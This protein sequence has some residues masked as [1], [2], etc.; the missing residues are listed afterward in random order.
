VI[1]TPHLVFVH[2]PRTGGTFVRGVLKDHLP[3]IQRLRGYMP[4]APYRVLDPSLRD[5]PGFHVIRNPWD[6]Y[7][8]WYHHMEARGPVLAATPPP[9]SPKKGRPSKKLLEK[10]ARLR[11]KQAAW[12]DAFRSGQASFREVVVGACDGRIALGGAAERRE[13]GLG[14]YSHIVWEIAERGVGPGALEALRYKSLRP[15]LERF[16][17]RHGLL[18]DRLRDAIAQD[19]PVDTSAHRP[20]R[21][22]YD[23]QL[24]DLVGLHAQSLIERYGYVF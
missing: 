18:G 17:D 5:R 20:Y 3:P 4:T 21:S 13:S 22:Y 10:Q 19:P 23:N 1:V 8:S 7:V 16:L 11:G 15:D 2:V 12:T 6:W 24:R 9:R 14:L